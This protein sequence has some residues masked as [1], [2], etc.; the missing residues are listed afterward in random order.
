VKRKIATVKAFMNHLENEDVILVNPFHKMR[1]SIKEGKQLPKTIEL[2]KIKK[3]FTSLYVQKENFK[4]MDSYAYK[5]LVRDIAV[6]ELLFA[7][8]MR[9][10]EL[11]NL[12]SENI[13]LSKGFVIIKGKGNREWIIPIPHKD[14]LKALKDYYDL[15][16]NKIFNNSYFFVNRLNY[17]LPEQSIRLMIK[18]HSKSFNL[19]QHIPPP[20]C[21]GIR[22]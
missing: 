12:K 15:F 6:L 2:K 11:A 9:V 17:R 21:S 5:A 7:T 4:R 3:L 10:S 18:K 8:G 13:N 16:R 20:T 19:Q 22:L 14:I 1:L